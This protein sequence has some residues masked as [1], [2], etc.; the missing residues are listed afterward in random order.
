V[1]HV[2]T[3]TR[4]TPAGKFTDQMASDIYKALDKQDVNGVLVV[5]GYQFE[6][7]ERVMDAI[8]DLAKH[9]QFELKKQVR[10][11]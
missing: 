9:L 10:K 8:H 5:E 4:L 3:L 1:P 11:R 6:N 7:K 2:V